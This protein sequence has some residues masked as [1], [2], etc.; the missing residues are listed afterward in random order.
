MMWH[1]EDFPEPDRP[2]SSTISPTRRPPPSR[3]SRLFSFDRA[4]APQTSVR[5]R[6][7]PR[8]LKASY[9]RTL[10]SR[11]SRDSILFDFESWTKHFLSMLS[12]VLFRRNQSLTRIFYRPK[13]RSCPYR[14]YVLRKS[15]S[16]FRTLFGTQYF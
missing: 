10:I 1:S 6:N 3:S 4:R 16:P 13:D 15:W 2:Q 9:V 14:T 7:A 5:R 11:F 12:M 8:T